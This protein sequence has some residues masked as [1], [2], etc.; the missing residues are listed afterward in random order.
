MQITVQN[1]EKDMPDLDVLAESAT[2][3]ANMYEF[4]SRIYL[5]EINDEFLQAIKHP[6]AAVAFEEMGIEF[7]NSLEADKG[8]DQIEILAEAYCSTFVLP[9]NKSLH[10]YESIQRQGCYQGKT[11]FKVED[12]YNKCSYKLPEE[13]PEFVDHIGLELDFISKLS[14]NESELWKANKC[15]EAESMLEKEIEFLQNHLFVWVPDYAKNMIQYASHPFYQ[16]VGLLTKTF[17]QF[18]KE[19]LC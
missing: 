14:K 5:S 17:M 10:P 15:S 8:S 9:V 4:L 12:F 18:E 1:L 19:Q 11:S 6:D 3:R 16:A 13:C 2:Y 7:L